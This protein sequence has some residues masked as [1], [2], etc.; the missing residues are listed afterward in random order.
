MKKIYIF[1]VLF[2]LSSPLFSQS[3]GFTDLGVLFSQENYNGT[4]R[5]NAMSGAFGALGGDISAIYQNPAGGAVF[6]RSEISG[7]YSFRNFNT[8]ASYYGNTS[9]NSNTSSRFPQFGIVIVFES[10]YASSN[11]TKFTLGFNYS[12]L[13]DFRGSY[14]VEGNNESFIRY[15]VHPFD[16]EAIPYNSPEEQYFE[17]NTDGFSEVYTLSLSS[18][19]R[20]FFYVGSSLN[21]HTIEFSQETYLLEFNSNEDGNTL[22]ADYTQYINENSTGVS[23]GIGIIVKPFRNLRLGLAY[24]SPIW[25]PEFA[26][27]SN[28]LDYDSSNGYTEIQEQGYLDIYSSDLESLYKN[29]TSNYPELLAYNYSLSTP[30]KWTASAAITLGQHGLIS[31]DLH[32][33]NYRL[34]R[35]KNGSDFSETNKEINNILTTARGIRGGGELRFNEI[36][37]RG[38]AFLEESPYKIEEGTIYKKGVSFGLGLKFRHTKLDFAYQYTE[39]DDQYSMYHDSEPVDN[40]SILNTTSRIT[41]TLSFTF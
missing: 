15:N 37:L 17:N 19:Y 23:L 6:A 20:D 2:A 40:I 13:N 3:L 30:E 7:S 22:R 31:V 29:T 39:I 9:F 41:S 18:A 11:W 8:D 27:E 32:Q 12:M 24:Q 38:G 25:H 35:L 10:P 26:E 34:I 1:S 4:A 28:A 5:Y 33:K 16:S 14:S 21:F 36:S